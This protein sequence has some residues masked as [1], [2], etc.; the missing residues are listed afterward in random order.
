MK[1]LT[2]QDIKEYALSQNI[3]LTNYELNIIYNFILKYYNDLLNKDDTPLIKL[4]DH[5][6][7][8]LYNKIISL[9][10]TYKIYI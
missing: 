9:Y 8:D 1:C 2:P 10:N 6:N 3:E 5:L 7:K 4:K